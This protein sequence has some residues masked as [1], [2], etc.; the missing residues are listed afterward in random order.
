VPAQ[1]V[2]AGVVDGDDVRVGEPGRHAALAAEEGARLLVV[3]VGV[4]D[5]D[6]HGPVEDLVAAQEDAGHS[7]RSELP[8][9]HEPPPKAV[10]TALGRRRD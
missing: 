9:E 4:Q 8:D 2:L 10:H 3:E 1:H 5:L 7:T 6:G